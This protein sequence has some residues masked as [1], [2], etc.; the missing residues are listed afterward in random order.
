[1]SIE[2]T[3]TTSSR[4][5]QALVE[6]NRAGTPGSG[7]V[8]TLVI[9]TDEG[10]AHDALKAA[11]E[12]SRE[13]PARILVVIKRPGPGRPGRPAGSRL[14]AELRVG[15]E[16]GAGEVVLLR[17][18]GELT[19]HA[20]SVVLPLLLPDAPVVAWWPEG[21]PDDVARDPLG[22]LA[23]RRITDAATAEAPIGQL[24]FRAP[25]YRP[26]DT[27][28]AWTR[29]T[30]WRS[31]L[32]AALD[33][34]RTDVQSAMVT[35][36]AENPSAELLARWIGNRLRVPVRQSVSDGP[37]ITAV[38]LHTHV[39]DIA[40]KRTDGQLATL[41][42][43]GEPDRRISLKRRETADLIA[44][45]LRRLDP[46]DIFA[47][48]VRHDV[49]EPAPTNGTTVESAPVTPAGHEHHLPVLEQGQPV[50][51]LAAANRTRAPAS[52]GHHDEEPSHV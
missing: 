21:G 13:H 37:G 49:G 22:A 9:D 45:E 16:A 20:D 24:A 14:D 51:T 48:A 38:R 25:A 35:G 50:H 34:L 2:L 40:L 19:R 7:T 44:E 46:D 1:M 43:P 10:G 39:G 52:W 27:D 6:A 5:N 11:A 33:E 8:L 4:I 3:N 47:A 32:A 29:I 23:Q 12:A 15:A 18:H 28:L 17:L 26:G 30:P 31:I 36:E 41:S 42:M